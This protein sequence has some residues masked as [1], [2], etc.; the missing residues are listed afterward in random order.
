[1]N[2]A[3]AASLVLPGIASVAAVLVTLLKPAGADV[4]DTEKAYELLKNAVE[5]QRAESLE[6][7]RELEELRAWLKVWTQYQDEHR[8]ATTRLT[9]TSRGPASVGSSKR[10]TQADR[11]GDGIDD[12]TDEVPEVPPMPAAKPVA[13]GAQPLPAGREVFK[14]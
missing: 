1:M 6:A 2:L 3:K 8:H 4:K 9:L 5:V 11:D 12:P 14:Q 13:S 7:R 10:V